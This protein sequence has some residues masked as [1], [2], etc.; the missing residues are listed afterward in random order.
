M[1]GVTIYA[2]YIERFTYVSFLMTFMWGVQ[3]GFFN[4]HGNSIL[5]S[6]FTQKS[7]PFAI[8][9]M[10]QGLVV[11]FMDNSKVRGWSSCGAQAPNRL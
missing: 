7:E 9:N 10:I 6:E 2:V 8:F 11:F 3:D 4:I 1:G 5:G